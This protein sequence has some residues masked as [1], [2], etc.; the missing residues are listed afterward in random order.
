[1]V[2]Y[3]DSNPSYI[4]DIYH[5][6][7]FVTGFISMFTIPVTL[8]IFNNALSEIFENRKFLSLRRKQLEKEFDYWYK[9]VERDFKDDI[10]KLHIAHQIKQD[11]FRTRVQ[12]DINE[13][14]MIIDRIRGLK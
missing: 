3:F 1:M 4:L 6:I 9:K 11:F 2:F 13:M 12:N 5:Q 7:T 8:F 14:Q 10:R